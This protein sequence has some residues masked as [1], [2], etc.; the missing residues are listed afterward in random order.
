MRPPFEPLIGGVVE[1]EQ[2]TVIRCAPCV[3]AVRSVI[4]T[5]AALARHNRRRFSGHCEGNNLAV[6]A[7]AQQV[8]KENYGSHRLRSNT[9]P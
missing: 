2:T 8:I 7:I 5:I 6:T 3:P 1:L 9:M 4:Q